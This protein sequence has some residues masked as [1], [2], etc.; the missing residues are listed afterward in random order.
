MS[1]RLGGQRPMETDSPSL[2]P[3]SLCLPIRL[4]FL[5]VWRPW[6]S[7]AEPAGSTILAEQPSSECSLTLSRSL[8]RRLFRSR[9]LSLLPDRSRNS[10]FAGPDNP[11]CD[12][13]GKRSNRNRH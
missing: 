8:L 1:A 2:L 3:E 9:E 7:S 5:T 6:R 13:F 4:V 11:A 12:Y 10:W